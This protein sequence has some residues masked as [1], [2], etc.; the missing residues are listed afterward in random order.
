MKFRIRAFSCFG[1]VAMTLAAAATGMAAE[2]APS[3]PV[4]FVVGFPPGGGG[5][6]VGRGAPPHTR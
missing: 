3:K 2:W 6:M 5:A 4:R 1:L